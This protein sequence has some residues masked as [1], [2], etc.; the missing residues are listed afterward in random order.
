MSLGPRV[1]PRATLD[2]QEMV[3]KSVSSADG[4][5]LSGPLCWHRRGGALGPSAQAVNGADHSGAA[6]TFPGVIW[7]E[8]AP[9]HWT[10]PLSLQGPILGKHPVFIC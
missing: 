9:S 7:N 10:Q 2:L 8:K 6:E 3:C 4:E 1:T 5:C